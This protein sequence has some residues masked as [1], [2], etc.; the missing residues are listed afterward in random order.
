VNPEES[1]IEEER[2][3]E[4][5]REWMDQMQAE[6]F[7]PDHDWRAQIAEGLK[8]DFSQRVQE[9]CQEDWQLDDPIYGPNSSDPPPGLH[10]TELNKLVELETEKE[11]NLMDWRTGSEDAS[12]SEWEEAD[13]NRKDLW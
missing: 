6:Q 3:E 12:H 2:E 9:L 5:D 10:S 4:L 8:G 1:N 7:S 13:S 11:S